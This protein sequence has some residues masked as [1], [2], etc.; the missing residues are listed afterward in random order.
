MTQCLAKNTVAQKTAEIRKLIGHAAQNIID[1]GSRLIEVKDALPHGDFGKWL[2]KEFGWKEQTA[3]NMMN[4]A[5]TFKNPNFGDLKIAPS[6]LYLLASPSTP[7]P[8][9]QEFVEKAAKDEKVTHAEVKRALAP[10]PEPPAPRPEEPHEAEAARPRRKT[11]GG[12]SPKAL[13]PTAATIPSPR[14]STSLPP[15]DPQVAANTLIRLFEP[16]WLADLVTHITQYLA[17]GNEI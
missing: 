1:I 15:D 10:L 16:E 4:V 11:Y 5:R 8:I 6:A 17:K 7:E 2:G 14:I 3:R 12:I 13:R 9:R